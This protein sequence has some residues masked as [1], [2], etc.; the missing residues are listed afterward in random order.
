LNNFNGLTDIELSLEI[1]RIENLK[2]V[3]VASDTLLVEPYEGNVQEYDPIND[4]GLAHYL[5]CKY[6][7]SVDFRMLNCYIESKYESYKAGCSY[8][9]EHE[10]PNRAI[11]EAI[12]DARE[13][14]E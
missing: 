5:Q 2:P 14:Y 7:V 3:Y 8:F 12:L 13:E 11:C 1:A 4:D 10:S 6:K 9:K